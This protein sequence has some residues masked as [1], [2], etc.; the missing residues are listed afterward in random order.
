MQQ[1]SPL[2]YLMMSWESRFTRNYRI[3]SDKAVLNP[4]SRASY[5]TML[6][7]ALKSR[8]TIYLNW[9][10]CGARSRTP[11]PA[12]C[13]C[14]ELSK[15]RVQWGSVKTRALGSGSLS[16]RPLGWLA[17]SVQLTTKLANT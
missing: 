2:T 5:S 16:S 13:L 8:C 11:T 6:L 15:K 7:V 1:Q 12:P 10:P 14:D 3:P 4:K 17:G 9:S